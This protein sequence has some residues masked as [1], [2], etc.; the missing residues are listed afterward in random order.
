MPIDVQE[1]GRKTQ[2]LAM[3]KRIVLSGVRDG[4]AGSKEQ[5]LIEQLDGTGIKSI[6]KCC[7]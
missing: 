1:E 7:K 3:C 4:G 2:F 6:W 5:V